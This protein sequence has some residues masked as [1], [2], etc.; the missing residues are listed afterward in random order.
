MRISGHHKRD[1][2]CAMSRFRMRSYG[3]VLYQIKTE[4]F[5]VVGHQIPLKVECTTAAKKKEKKNKARMEH[6]LVVEF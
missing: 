6:P 2:L 1:F 3:E 5:F 4:G